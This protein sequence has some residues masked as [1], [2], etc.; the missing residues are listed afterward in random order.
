MELDV[1]V[2]L[3]QQDLAEVKNTRKVKWNHLK[4]KKVVLVQVK[5]DLVEAVNRS[6]QY[7][8]KKSLLRLFSF[9]AKNVKLLAYEYIYSNP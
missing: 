3:N 4:V 6:F 2:T 9:F 8:K 7:T 5:P 1:A